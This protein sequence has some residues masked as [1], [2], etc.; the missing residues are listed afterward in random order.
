MKGM[1]IDEVGYREV[2]FMIQ[3]LREKGRT[4]L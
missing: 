4:L 3:N 2:Y 1:G